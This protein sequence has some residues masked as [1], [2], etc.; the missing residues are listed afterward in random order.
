MERNIEMIDKVNLE[1]RGARAVITVLGES[2]LH[3][4]TEESL[5]ELLGDVATVVEGHIDAARET[6]RKWIP[7]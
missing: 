1:L 4:Y 6:L 3:E 2:R 5:A 7:N